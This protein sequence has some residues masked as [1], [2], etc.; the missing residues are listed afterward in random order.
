LKTEK[1]IWLTSVNET[2]A[3]LMRRQNVVVFREVRSVLNILIFL[4][5]QLNEEGIYD[6]WAASLKHDRFDHVLK[7]LP[8]FSHVLYCVPRCMM[9]SRA[10]SHAC[11]LH[12]TGTDRSNDNSP[13]PIFSNHPSKISVLL[14][15]LESAF[16]SMC[17][18]TAAANR[19]PSA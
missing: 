12:S 10:Q 11:S 16:Q 3:H 8:L 17:A 2:L 19:A 15:P 4:K 13:L 7:G 1:S 6:I 9:D 18:D 5:V 14:L